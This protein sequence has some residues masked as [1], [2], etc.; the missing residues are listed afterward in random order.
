MPEKQRNGRRF[1]ME[2]SRWFPRVI[3]T[4]RGPATIEGQA[5]AAPIEREPD[6]EDLALDVER[7]KAARDHAE[8]RLE[9]LDQEYE[10]AKRLFRA[11][12]QERG[13]P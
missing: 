8:G 11:K 4:M 6:L 7:A 9:V 12:C 5:V 1:G 3:E 13:L 2:N 10:E